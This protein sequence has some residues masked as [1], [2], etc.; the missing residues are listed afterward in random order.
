MEVLDGFR[1]KKQQST[2]GTRS[3]AM[4]DFPGGYRMFSNN[5]VFHVEKNNYRNREIEDSME[6]AASMLSLLQKCPLLG[7]TNTAGHFDFL[8]GWTPVATPGTRNRWKRE[9]LATVNVC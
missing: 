6:I 8:F 1:E 4:C 7:A 5:S 9:R 2:N 3:I